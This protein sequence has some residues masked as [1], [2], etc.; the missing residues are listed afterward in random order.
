LEESFARIKVDSQRT[1][2]AFKP[3]LAGLRRLRSSLE[4][5]PANAGHQSTKEL[6]RTLEENGRL[7]KEGLA[8]V[9]T[10][11][12]RMTVLITPAK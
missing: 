10:E 8:A 9:G 1:R 11:L 7:V 5:D 6:V 3:F 12:N 2:A 4:N